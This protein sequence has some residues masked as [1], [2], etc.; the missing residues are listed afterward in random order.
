MRD[1]LACV[2]CGKDM[3]DSYDVT[4][5]G[6]ATDHLLP[7]NQYKELDSQGWNRVLTCRACNSFKQ[8]WNPNDPPLLH[9]RGQPGVAVRSELLNRAKEFVRQKRQA[10]RSVVSTRTA[11][12][13]RAFKSLKAGLAAAANRASP[14]YGRNG[15]EFHS[16]LKLAILIFIAAL[17]F[18]RIA[19][20]QPDGL[21]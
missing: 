18:G 17:V 19:V 6:Y 21:Q 15:R 9:P 1:G 2:Y 4:Y 14:S 20:A 11:G 16:P 8:D 13:Q 10:R 12:I 7:V 5:H 3:L